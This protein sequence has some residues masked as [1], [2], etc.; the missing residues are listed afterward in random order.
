MQR[1]A[2]NLGLDQSS[3]TAGLKPLTRRGLVHS[4]PSLED[5]RQRQLTLTEEGKALL[6]EASPLWA[7]AQAQ[8]EASLRHSTAEAL[9]RDLRAFA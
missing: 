3:L 7:A 1:L 2:D 9:R 4:T 8:A 5:R 6:K